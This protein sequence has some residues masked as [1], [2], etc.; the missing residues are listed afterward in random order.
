MQEV[1][2]HRDR[3]GGAV[4]ALVRPAGVLVSG[5][6][7]NVYVATRFGNAVLVFGRDAAAA[8]SQ[9]GRVSFT[10]AHRDGQLG[11]EG[12][13]GAYAMTM[14]ADGKHLYVASESDNAVVLFDRDAGGALIRRQ[15]WTKGSTGLP[16]LGGAQAIALSND[17][18]ELY[19]AGFADHSL[20]V[21]ARATAN[22]PGVIA[23]ALVPRQTV[24]DGD[25]GLP[26]M[27][28][29]LAIAM[30]PDSLHVYVA[31]NIDNAIVRFGRLEA[32]GDLFG[33]GFE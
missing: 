14:S 20:T 26:A 29:P 4:Q 12:L 31:A 30:S 16:G 18:T 33:D 27:A 2:F 8:S 6:G 17:E 9:F 5:D 19:V 24:F 28:G 10:T 11:I 15:Q 32:L 3:R 25:V 21:F 23:G 22:A 1:Q 7:N 13:A